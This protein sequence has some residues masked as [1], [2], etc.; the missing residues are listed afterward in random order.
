[1]NADCIF[2]K[3][4]SRAI[5]APLLHD[6]PEV[7]AFADI[8]PQ[9]PTHLLVIPRLHVRDLPALIAGGHEAL[10]GRL[11]TVAGQVAAAAG[12]IKDGYRLVVNTGAH[13]GQSVFHLHLH[14]LGGRH[15]GWPPG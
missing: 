8:S 5:P 2:C 9:A 3:I 12:L 13:G 6:D 7:I 11:L 10:A 1:M 4:A 15:L 14:I